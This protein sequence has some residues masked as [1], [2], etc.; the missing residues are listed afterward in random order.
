MLTNALGV[1]SFVR[2]FELASVGG[3][4]RLLAR[5]LR[6]A[7]DDEGAEIGRPELDDA[8]VTAFLGAVD[9]ALAAQDVAAL[10]NLVAQAAACCRACA[11]EEAGIRLYL[12]LLHRLGRAALLR[13]GADA[14]ATTARIRELVEEMTLRSLTAAEPDALLGAA[15]RFLGWLDVTARILA[16]R[17][18]ADP[19]AARDLTAAAIAGRLRILRVMDPDPV[20]PESRDEL[21]T[22]L[23][24]PLALVT[25]VRDFVEYGG[26]NVPSAFYGVHQILAG[27]KFLGNFY[28]GD[29]TLSALRGR[30]YGPSPAANPAAD[31]SRAA[32]GAVADFDGLWVLV[33]AD[34][35]ATMA[36]MRTRTPPEL[37]DP[38][39]ARGLVDVSTLL[40]TFAGHRWFGDAGQAMDVLMQAVS[41]TPPEDSLWARSQARSRLRPAF[42]DRAGPLGRPAAVVMAVAVR[43]AP[44]EP[45]EPDDELRAFLDALPGPVRVAVADLAR[46]VLPASRSAEPESG[47]DAATAAEATDFVVGRLAATLQATGRH[48]AGAAA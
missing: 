34:A 42:P 24:D 41:A 17:G 1:F 26:S 44:L 13:G 10:R 18:V 23:E 45:G 20:S 39:V 37:A 25:W 12:E 30:L 7:L 29:S 40:R 19:R 16:G 8:T 36:D 38:A 35:I 9:E 15:A 28:Y 47:A 46:R 11:L 33:S 22:P 31:R 43:L 14:A 4:N 6:R 48:L 2:L 3:R 27:E 21:G 32:F 5:T